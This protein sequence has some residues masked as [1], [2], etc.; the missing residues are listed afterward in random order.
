[1]KLIKGA[2]LMASLL[3]FSYTNAQYSNT[4]VDYD[5]ADPIPFASAYLVDYEIGVIADSNG[6]FRF[7]NQLPEVFYLKISASGYETRVVVVADSNRNEMI[8]LKTIHIEFDEISVSTPRGGLQTKS[9]THVESRKLAE[10]DEIP[11]TNLG[12]LL[13]HIPGV[14][15]ATSGSGVS[16][17]VVRGFQG[18]RVV[19]LLN[20]VR[21][22]NQQWGGDHDFGLTDL[23]IGR[24]EV[25]KGP[26]SLL[27]GADALGGVIYFADEDYAGQNQYELS[28]GSQFVSNT[29]GTK[30]NLAFKF[31]K[32][33]I[34]LNIAG[35]YTNYADYQIPDGHFVENSR[36][37]GYAGK[38][39]LGANWK[40]WVT[41]VRYSYSKSLVGIIGGHH[42]D[43]EEEHHH[44]FEIESQ[45]RN[46]TIPFQAY[47]NHIVSWKN[48]FFKGRNEWMI[49][50]GHSNNKLSEFEESMD[51]AAMAL[52]LNN[53]SYSLRYKLSIS[54]TLELISGVQGA[55]QVNTNSGVEEQLIPDARQIDNGI[56]SILYYTKQ[57]WSIQGGVR[58]DL[59]LL[60]TKVEDS[61]EVFSNQYGSFNF[62]L[63]AVRSGKKNTF[64]AN[65]SSGFR[66]PHL[67]ELLADGL[68]H[69]AL[70]YEVGNRSL[71]SERAFQLDITDEIH[72][73]HIEIV[74][75]PFLNYIQNY[76]YLEE[77]DSLIEDLP[78]FE[79]QQLPRAL[80][81]GGDLA[82]HYHPHFA[83]WLHWEPS[84]SFI[85]GQD[86]KGQAIPF[87][88]QARISNE[89]KMEFWK[90]S[91]LE[92]TV[93]L[94]YMYYFRQA[95]VSGLETATS[96]YNLVNLGVNMSFT[97]RVPLVLGFGVKNLFNENYV[98]HLSRLK[99]I[100]L[101][102]PGRN[103]YV[104]LKFNLTGKFKRK[105]TLSVG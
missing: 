58:Y 42:E 4:I 11:A 102:N 89:L 63:G 95:R 14:Y 78:V 28:I 40:N 25:I 1:M 75:N 100:G 82:V 74:L 87:M 88:P 45:P 80:I 84:L 98:D 12:E 10:L 77:T 19:S 79:Y 8:R 49:L 38:F 47:E 23:G 13:Q 53:T 104:R 33:N 5:S 55:F 60:D 68:H 70:R 36:F 54:K 35:N 31:S 50:L 43:E 92:S 67:S 29:M 62:S 46:I 90:G 85:Y 27:Y 101:S 52:T 69:G 81:A 76:I 57:K 30:N 66:V 37:N 39:A 22:E 26:A 17:P 71:K 94:Q 61:M 44:E 86:D 34:R 59:R 9:A 91:I 2:L 48:K 51:E 93:V 83:H 3:T 56:Y 6:D 73:E 32:Y 103:Y 18:V 99:N 72:G 20:G 64:R 24:V 97:D 16:K 96:D 105:K 21:L 41:H 65:I 7:E 15:A